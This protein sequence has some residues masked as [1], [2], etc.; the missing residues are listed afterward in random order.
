MDQ[1]Y[2]LLLS[3]S[4]PIPITWF[5]ID[6]IRKISIKF[7]VF[8]VPN[9]RSSHSKIVPATGG[10]ALLISWLVIILLQTPLN[11]YPL[12]GDLYFFM[13][14]GIIIAIVGFYD[15]LK[16]MPSLLK[17]LMQVFV[18]F[19]ISFTDNILI[20][21]FH[22]L[23]GI[24][25]IGNVESVI[26][27][28]FVFIVIVNSINL[29]DGIDGLS[30]SLS[31]FFLMISSYI[32]YISDYYYLLLLLSFISTLFVF[33][34]FNFSTTK[35][36]FLGDTGSLGLGLFIAVL[37]LSFLN[38]NHPS[39]G[40]FPFNPA[41]FVVLMLSY[42][43]LDVIR[44]FIIRIYK[45]KSFM[46]P[47][48]NHIHHKLVDIGLSHKE[49]VILIVLFQ[50]LFLIINTVLSNVLSLHLLILINF[51]IVLTITFI[52]YKIP[53]KLIS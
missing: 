52:L 3:I 43:L 20:N 6:I 27:S 28:L 34:Y 25:E 26:F 32:Y 44:V 23:F 22:G 5:S 50:L 48:R 4:I 29:V 33:L 7:R 41:L 49:S 9:E 17:L 8:A 16:E 19:I 45:R 1:F 47:D 46:E 21:S 18:F 2:L 31:L 14:A 11:Q 24:Y 40:Y 37:S 38:T 10:L 35:K 42:P 30:A 13:L 12:N 36:I 15:D 51:I 39:F 53:N